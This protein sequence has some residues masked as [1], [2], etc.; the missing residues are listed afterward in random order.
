MIGI[1][2]AGN[3]NLSIERRQLKVE[4]VL[5]GSQEEDLEK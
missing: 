1:Q 3:Q 5:S 2:N 4:I